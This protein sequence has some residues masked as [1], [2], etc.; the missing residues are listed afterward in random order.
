VSSRK[1]DYASHDETLKRV[2]GTNPPV[3]MANLPLL[4]DTVAA[5]VVAGGDA[6]LEAEN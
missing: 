3:G 1:F 2:L 5:K 6:A 4:A